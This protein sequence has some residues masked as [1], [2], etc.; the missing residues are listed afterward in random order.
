MLTPFARF[1][2]PIPR[3]VEWL[4]KRKGKSSSVIALMILQL[5]QL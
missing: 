3:I 2:E 5:L 4:A 1:T